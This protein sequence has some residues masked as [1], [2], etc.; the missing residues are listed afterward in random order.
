MVL[1]NSTMTTYEEFIQQSEERDGIRFTWNVWP[2]SRLEATRLVVPVA[3]LYQPLKE[4][5]DLPPI[6]YE[7]VQC[8]RNTCRA[9]LN[10]M[11][12]VDYRAKLWVCNFCFQRNPFPPQ[13]SAISEHHQPA[14]LIPSFSTIEYIIYR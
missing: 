10:P 9:I 12:Q 2:S 13:Y 8:T 4:R 7:P 11:C 14:E 5:Y 3:C 1:L 6:L